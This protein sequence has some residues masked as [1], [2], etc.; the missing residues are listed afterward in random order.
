MKGCSACCEACGVFVR[1]NEKP[2]DVGT[3]LGDGLNGETMSY[4]KAA[5]TNP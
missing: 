5:D 2:Q 1:A 4:L 3:A